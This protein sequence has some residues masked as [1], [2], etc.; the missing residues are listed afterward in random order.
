MG[1]L[2][3]TLHDCDPDVW[4]LQEITGILKN[5]G[6]KGIVTIFYRK[7]CIRLEEGLVKVSDDADAMK[8]VETTMSICSK[9]VEVYVIQNGDKE[10]GVL[11]TL[12]EEGVEEAQSQSEEDSE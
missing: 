7:P 6:Y 5:I 3:Y 1:G 2:K 8:I 4:S 11:L 9:E 12:E 10:D